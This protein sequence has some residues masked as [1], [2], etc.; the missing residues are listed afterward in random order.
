MNIVDNFNSYDRDR[1]HQKNPMD[2]RLEDLGVSELTCK[3]LSKMGIATPFHL[4]QAGI[5]HIM[6]GGIVGK[7]LQRLILE[8]ESCGFDADK[9]LFSTNEQHLLAL[10]LPVTKVVKNRDLVKILIKNNITKV[11]DIVMS[12][13]QT[14]INIFYD[15]G[16]KFPFAPAKEIMDSMYL[17]AGVFFN[18]EGNLSFSK[19]KVNLHL[20]PEDTLLVDI[21][22]LPK[23]VRTKLLS[24]GYFDIADFKKVDILDVYGLG[25]REMRPLA[26]KIIDDYVRKQKEND[27]EDV[28]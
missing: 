1:G 15:Q 8:L 28:R 25:R 19:P 20:K 27:V 22:E 12:G 18:Q 9:I 26:K 14:L 2:M 11:K 5:S 7:K 24:Y 16:V 10:N 17:N 3:K 23:S 4:Q 6:N 21:D 13:E